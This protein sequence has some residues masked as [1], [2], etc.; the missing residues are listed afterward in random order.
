MS[1]RAGFIILALV[2]SCTKVSVPRSP[3]LM[4]D[5]E[6]VGFGTEIGLGT[7]VGAAP[8]DSLDLRN[9]G[10][11][12]LIISSV[13]LDGSRAFT[14]IGPEPRTIAGLQHSFVTFYFRP[15]AP[16]TYNATFTIN[17]NASN[18]PTRVIPIRGTAVAPPTDGGF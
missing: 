5:R 15:T 14:Y 7:Y 10:T 1:T 13:S 2:T 11:N 17:S 18:G 3:Q 16:G 4:I 8:Q 12:D 6:L 9:A